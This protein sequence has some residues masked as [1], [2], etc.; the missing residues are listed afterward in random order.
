MNADTRTAASRVQSAEIRAW[1][2]DNGWPELKGGRGRIP[3]E[4]IDAFGLA[5]GEPVEEEPDVSA[6]DETDLDGEIPFSDQALADYAEDLEAQ[7]AAPPADLDEARRRVGRDPEPA[8]LVRGRGRGR[9]PASRT[10]KQ[11]TEPDIKVTEAVRDDITGKLAFWLSIPAEPWLRVDPYCGQAYADQVDEIALKMAPLICLSP[12]MVRWF[13]KSST[14]I[15]W[16]E[17]GIAVR[18]VVE[19]IIAHHVTKRIVLDSNGEAVEVAG[20]GVDF[21]AYSARQPASAA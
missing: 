9:K 16:T 14:F 21:S 17:L 6:M 2:A 4:A 15:M 5:H 8:H 3:A 20:G 18:P 11:P 10:P 19:A 12:D 7:G 13:A 1:A